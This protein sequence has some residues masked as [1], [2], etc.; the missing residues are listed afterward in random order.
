MNEFLSITF[1][2]WS[3]KAR[4]ALEHHKVPHKTTYHVPFTGELSLRLRLRK[5]RETATAP[6]FFQNGTRLEDSWD[7]A[8]RAEELGQGTP[9]FPSEH[10][11]DIERWNALSE[12]A[13]AEGRIQTI[14]R[15][16]DNDTAL[17]AELP[18][19]LPSAL[20]P[21][22]VKLAG[23][24][25]RFLINKYKSRAKTGAL[26]EALSELRTALG[27]NDG[28][29]IYSTFSYADI[30]MAAVLQF[31]NPVSDEYL[32]LSRR[33]RPYWID[34]ELTTEYADLIEWR[35]KL[36]ETYRRN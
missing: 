4:W 16:Q 35:D 36:Y 30:S 15:V 12:V 20:N 32:R 9:L 19:K 21:A 18:M 34:K 27:E 25:S 29:T 23:L 6:V 1:S 22:G 8:L 5:F 7:I 31:V 11:Q 13:L 24:G 14:R 3:E 33:T 26:R 10:L 28:R 17:L 2:P